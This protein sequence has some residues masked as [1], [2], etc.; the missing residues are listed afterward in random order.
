MTATCQ[1]QKQQINNLIDQWHLAAANA[2]FDSYFNKMTIDGIFIGTDAHENWTV[3]EFKVY[4]KPYFDKGKAWSFNAL[5]RNVYISDGIAH[6]D[7][8]LETQMGL[9][10]GSG[11]VTKTSDGWKIAHYVL[12]I[13]VPNEQVSKLTAIKAAHDSKY[14][15]SLK[16]LTKSKRF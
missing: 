7:E 9:C 6:F 10:R 15:D 12:S 13:V 11:V 3:P 4:A 2:D 8:L 5:Q 16:Q 14:A 1:S